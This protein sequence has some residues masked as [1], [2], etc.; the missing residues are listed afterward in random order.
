KMPAS[1]DVVTASVFLTFT[2][3]PLSGL[4]VLPSMTFPF[5]LTSCANKWTGTV[6]VEITNSSTSSRFSFINCFILNIE[7]G[8]CEN[9]KSGLHD[10][11][12]RKGIFVSSVKKRRYCHANRQEEYSCQEHYWGQAV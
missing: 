7:W 9:S 12:D 11:V 8:D 3:A 6:S 4:F 2:V 1:S 5:T 10:R